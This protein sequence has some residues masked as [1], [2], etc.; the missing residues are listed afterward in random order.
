MDLFLDPDA[1]RP[2][3]EQLYEQLRHAITDG[4]LRP[5][6]Q[7]VPSRLLASQ[8]GAS[9]HTVATAYYRLVA[10]GYAEGHAGGGRLVAPPWPVPRAARPAAAPRPGRRATAWA[11]P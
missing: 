9:R 5:G 6:D 11:P 4:R 8:L 10:A 1:G 2:L 3:T 7:L